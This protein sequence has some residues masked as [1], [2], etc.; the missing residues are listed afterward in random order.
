MEGGAGGGDHGE[1]REEGGGEGG[2]REGEAMNKLDATLEEMR[3]LHNRNFQNLQI[4]IPAP[5]FYGLIITALE[6]ANS[7]IS[8]LRAKVELLSKENHDIP[9]SIPVYP[10]YPTY[11]Q[12]PQYPWITW[13]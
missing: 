9:S 13:C 1:G 2:K 12:W 10:V 3:R 11:P 8:E 7:E 6:E 4:L 5:E